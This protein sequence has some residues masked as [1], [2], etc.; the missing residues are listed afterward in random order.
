M[1]KDV[2]WY[3]KDPD[4]V[5]LI[6]RYFMLKVVIESGISKCN[7]LVLSFR[8]DPSS[9]HQVYALPLWLL[10]A[11][12]YFSF[13]F[14]WLCVSLLTCMCLCRHTRVWKPVVNT[15]YHSARVVFSFETGSLRSGTYSSNLAYSPRDPPVSVCLGAWQ[16]KI[17]SHTCMEITSYMGRSP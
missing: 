17:R 5:L 13:F 4:S 2:Q 12:L 9:R 6:T 11:C 16:A 3:R 14:M 7:S 10:A 8:I 1:F 15:R